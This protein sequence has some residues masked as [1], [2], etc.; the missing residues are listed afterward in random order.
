MLFSYLMLTSFGFYWLV[1]QFRCIKWWIYS[2]LLLF[3]LLSNYCRHNHCTFINILFILIEYLLTFYLYLKQLFLQIIIF[4]QYKLIKFNQILIRILI[5]PQYLFRILHILAQ[6][7]QHTRIALNNL[8]F[9]LLI[10][11]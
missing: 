7:V 3:L 9:L 1:M 5:R 10:L 8:I 6:L 2:F 4:L 11:Y